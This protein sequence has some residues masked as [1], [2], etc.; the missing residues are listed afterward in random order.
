LEDEGIVVNYLEKSVVRIS[1]Q[2]AEG[3]G[4][5][6]SRFCTGVEGNLLMTENK[7]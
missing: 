5:K 3:R 4:I 2:S 7:A 1:R 6:T